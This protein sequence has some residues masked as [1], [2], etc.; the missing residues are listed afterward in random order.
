MI[1]GQSHICSAESE[2]IEFADRDWLAEWKKNWR[3]VEL[4]I[5]HRPPWIES[6][7]LAHH[8]A[9]PVHTDYYSH[10]SRHGF[11]HGHAQTTRLC[12]KAI[13][14][15]FQ[16]GSFLDV[17]PGN[18]QFWQLRRRKCFP[19]RVLKRATPTRKQSK[20]RKTTPR[21]NDVLIES[22]SALAA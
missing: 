17:A 3:P 20:L 10:Q 1:H 21:L 22:I 5:H 16:G 9:D 11:R 14:K 18:R 19:M 8:S 2:D 13:E 7:A 15:Y 6:V 12:L 4:P